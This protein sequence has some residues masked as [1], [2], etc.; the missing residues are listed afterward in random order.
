MTHPNIN[1]YAPNELLN[2][3]AKIFETSNDN[4]DLISLKDGLDQSSK[5][6]LSR[7]NDEQK[8][9]FHF[10][11]ANGWGYVLRLKH[12]NSDEIP[13]NSK[14][15]EKEIFHLRLALHYIGTTENVN[16]CQIYT[17]LGCV[18]DHI[19]R[20]S[21]A[22]EYFN[23]ALAIDSNFGMA[24]GNKGLGLYWYAR[25][26]FDGVHQ[27]IFLQHAR[28]YLLESTQKQDVY[29]KARISFRDLADHI[30]TGY[31]LEDLNDFKI[32]KDYLQHLSND[33]ILYRQ[34]C[35][36][37]GL[38][39]NPLNDVLNQNIVAHDILHTPTM[40]LKRDEK[41]IYLSMYNQMKQEFVSARYLFYEGLTT[42][43][44]HFSDK[45]VVLYRAFD[46]PLYSLPLEKVKIAFR[47]CYSIFD[48]IAYLIN[49]YLDLNVDKNRVSFRNIWHKKGNRNNPIN[50]EIFSS[51]NR[52]L[53]AL[54]W[55]SKDLDE[56]ANSPI[57]PEAKEIALMRNFIEHKSFKIVDLKNACWE[58]A[59]ETY[60]IE[61]FDFNDKVFKILKLTRSAL[62]YLSAFLYEEES[63]RAIKGATK[64]MTMD[65]I[66]DRAK[67]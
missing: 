13:I 59:P 18:F 60:E 44:T 58:E 17:N 3:F 37:H 1:T 32:Y 29:T 54:F 9:T 66:D 62:I 42:E 52:A 41:P 27:F 46:F 63:N 24:L 8:S 6:D 50:E 15:V 33:E 67:I 22:Q 43:T 10:F 36:D 11:V 51:Q 19:G 40:I 14:E 31:P 55:L 34:W 56:G 2:L 28:K 49:I 30:A 65:I 39:L 64:T 4:G 25:V 48:K 35:M 57:E 23:K 16:A 26:V 7:F 5:V 45:D 53:Q 21:E 12:Q 61:R 38:F 47:V 20:Y